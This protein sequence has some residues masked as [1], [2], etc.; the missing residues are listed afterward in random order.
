MHLAWS[1]QTD[2]SFVGSP[3]IIIP[4]ICRC[5]HVCG[6]GMT[7]YD[8]TRL[9]QAFHYPIYAMMFAAFDWHCVTATAVH[10]LVTRV[11]HWCLS[12]LCCSLAQCQGSHETSEMKFHDFS[13]TFQDKI[14][15]FPWPF[16]QSRFLHFFLQ[17]FTGNSFLDKFRNHHIHDYILNANLGKFLLFHDLSFFD[18]PWPQIFP[19]LS[20][21]VGTLY[22]YI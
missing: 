13:L 3:C 11:N 6:I 15:D 18:F 22:I 14:S 2:P 16:P 8:G 4:S 5:H 19:W 17:F 9:I 12:C 21:T 20:M 7:L 1:A 10:V